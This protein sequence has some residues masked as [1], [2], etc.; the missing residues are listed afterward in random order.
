MLHL[1][2]NH[3]VGYQL[4]PQQPHLYLYHRVVGNYATVLMHPKFTSEWICVPHVCGSNWHT[5]CSLNISNWY[6]YCIQKPDSS[7]IEG[8][9]RQFIDNIINVSSAVINGDGV[10]WNLN[11][12]LT[13]KDTYFDRL[14]PAV[15]CR[16]LDTI[17]VI[18]YTDN[19]RIVGNEIIMGSNFCG[20]SVLKF[21]L[22]CDH[23]M[24][25][26]LLV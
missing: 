18:I 7:P 26:I 12:L 20:S 25:F 1:T 11:N 21:Q 6:I 23:I 14:I 15:V 22:H 3:Y 17:T 13:S 8:L 5:S 19:Y 16:N 2:I 10:L 4:S 24:V 9:M